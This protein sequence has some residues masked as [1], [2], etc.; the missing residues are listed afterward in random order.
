VTNRAATTGTALT[1]TVIGYTVDGAWDYVLPRA[2]ADRYRALFRE[3]MEFD[4]LTEAVAAGDVYAYGAATVFLLLKNGT[5]DGINIT[6]VRP[7]NMHRRCL[8]DGLLILYGSEGGDQVELAF[9]LEAARPV[10]HSRDSG[11][12]PTAE[13]YFDTHKSI[14]IPA[15][16][17]LNLNLDFSVSRYAY[18]FD[19]ELEYVTGGTKKTQVI[20][21]AKGKPFL[22]T[23]SDC[24]SA[25]TRQRLGGADLRRLQNH[26]YD[27]VRQKGW[28]ADSVPFVTAVPPETYAKQCATR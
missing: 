27:A 6:G 9:D 21:A 12:R 15:G 7:V 28:T 26:R 4:L 23:A 22:A 19:V 20:Q 5:G 13:L 3:E 1:T 17:T 2:A 11:D 8:P 14:E 24:P 25:A 16:D 18:A 10:A